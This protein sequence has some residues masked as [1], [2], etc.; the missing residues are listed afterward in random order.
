MIE[1]I[2]RVQSAKQRIV[3]PRSKNNTNEENLLYTTVFLDV[4]WGGE[5]KTL[6]VDIIDVSPI[7]KGFVGKTSKEKAVKIIKEKAKTL[8]LVINSNDET[9]DGFK[10]AVRVLL[11]G[12]EDMI[13]TEGLTSDEFS[14]LLCDIEE[15]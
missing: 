10:N 2:I 8:P 1:R 4:V 13:K 14:K 3:T 15:L 7:P 9:E 11:T 12:R 5:I 6:G